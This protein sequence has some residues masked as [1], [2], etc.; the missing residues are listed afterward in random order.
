[1]SCRARIY[2]FGRLRGRIYDNTYTSGIFID[3]SVERGG[4]KNQI[5]P[6][7]LHFYLLKRNKTRN[8]SVIITI[9]YG[10]ASVRS[11]LNS[12]RLFT[13]KIDLDDKSPTLSV[14]NYQQV[15]LSYSVPNVL[16]NITSY[17]S[18]VSGF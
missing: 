1:M 12:H 13:V 2:K 11:N 15:P 6:F 8:D 7:R 9:S 18:V 4:K 10:L 5:I 16:H 3:V 17:I 14:S